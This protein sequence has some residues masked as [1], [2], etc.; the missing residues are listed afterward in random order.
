MKKRWCAGFPMALM[1]IAAWTAQALLKPGDFNI[2]LVTSTVELPKF[3]D[4]FAASSHLAVH[5][6]QG[7]RVLDWGD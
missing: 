2:E 1:C 5:I 6:F 7:I 3:R 4:V